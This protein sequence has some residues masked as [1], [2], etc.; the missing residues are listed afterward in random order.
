MI[1]PFSLYHLNDPINKAVKEPSACGQVGPISFL[2][3]FTLNQRCGIMK[4]AKKGGNN[5]VETKNRYFYWE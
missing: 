3:I 1:R 2:K 4:D 5:Y